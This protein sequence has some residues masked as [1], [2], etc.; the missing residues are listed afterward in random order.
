MFQGCGPFK[1]LATRAAFAGM[2]DRLVPIGK[3]PCRKF[4]E[5]AAM[6]ARVAV[7]GVVGLHAC[8]YVLL[9]EFVK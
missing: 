5:P 9:V 8:D 6:A 7:G 2:H 1:E 3:E 4:R